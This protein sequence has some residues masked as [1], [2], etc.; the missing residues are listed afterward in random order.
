[1][2]IPTKITCARIALI[3][4]LLIG[5]FVSEFFLPDLALFTIGGS[6]IN[7]LYLIALI[8]FVVAASTDYLDGHLARKWNQVTDLGKFLDPIADKLLV[9]TM[10]IYLAIPRFDGQ[11]TIPVFA[12]V[13][14]IAR[15]LV[16]DAL[17]SIAASKGKVLAANMFGKLKTVCQMVMIPLVLLNGWPFSLFDA[18]WPI[19]LSVTDFV[20]YLTTAVSFLSGFVYVYQNR[21]VFL[22]EKHD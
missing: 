2:N 19:G 17:R 21:S 16:V 20:I 22:E 5:L 8:V 15:D 10:L 14:M 6:S 11:M 7:G 9:D 1:M 13:V 18:A 3:V 4:L 12:V